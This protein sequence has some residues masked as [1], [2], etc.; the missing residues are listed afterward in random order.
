MGLGWEYPYFL[1]GGAGS[2]GA[3]ET[4]GP[5]LR[6]RGGGACPGFPVT[7]RAVVIN[8]HLGMEVCFGN[9]V[10]SQGTY[11]CLTA[12]RATAWLRD[13]MDMSSL[14]G[15]FQNWWVG[16][17]FYFPTHSPIPICA[18]GRGLP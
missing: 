16:L 13:R 14:Y 12:D 17:T 1:G 6:L 18:V 5:Q 15:V 8:A 11:L 10:S 2:P 7:Q 3:S 9:H 4:K